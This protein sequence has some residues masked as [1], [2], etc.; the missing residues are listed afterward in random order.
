MSASVA[1][2]L[3]IVFGIALKVALLAAD[4]KYRADYHKWFTPGTEGFRLMMK[5]PVREIG[6]YVAM[7]LA[8]AVMIWALTP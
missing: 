4:P 8:F 2:V 7:A 6:W 1:V 3:W 5:Y